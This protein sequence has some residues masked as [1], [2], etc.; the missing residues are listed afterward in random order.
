MGFDLFIA[1]RRNR[2]P[3]S[4]RQAFPIGIFFKVS[5]YRRRNDSENLSFRIQRRSSGI[6]VERRFDSIPYHLRVI[7]RGQPNPAD[8][9]SVFYEQIFQSSF[10]AKTA[11]TGRNAAR[12][13]DRTA[14]FRNTGSGLQSSG[15]AF[16]DFYP[17]GCREKPLGIPSVRIHSI[18]FVSNAMFRRKNYLSAIR[19]SNV[20]EI[21][22][23]LPERAGAGSGFD[24]SRFDDFRC[25]YFLDL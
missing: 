22:P 3:E 15:C 8:G 16:G 25:R 21:A 19:R 20:R 23:P 10:D 6:P 13:D 2:Y 7:G 17:D 24:N 14:V 18:E 5:L 11:V 4:V 12:Q 1:H 9:L